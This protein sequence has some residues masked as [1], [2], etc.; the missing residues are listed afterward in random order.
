MENEKQILDQQA[1]FSLKNNVE[2]WFRLM[3][4]LEAQKQEI[5]NKIRNAEQQ[6]KEGFSF[7]KG[8]ILL[9]GV[10]IRCFYEFDEITYRNYTNEAD[11]RFK[12]YR[13]YTGNNWEKIELEILNYQDLLKVKVLIP[14]Q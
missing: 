1:I 9:I 3:D 4:Q 5:R 11:F 14:K 12:V 10:R 8:D 6:I 13:D 7:K 2:S